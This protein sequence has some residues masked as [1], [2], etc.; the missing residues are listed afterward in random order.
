MLKRQVIRLNMVPIVYLIKMN[1][2]GR[3]KFVINDKG[4]DIVEFNDFVPKVLPQP[5]LNARGQYV[6]TD[7]LNDVSG[8]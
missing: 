6:F 7:H 4:T 1:G 5:F 3:K 2:S 8:Y